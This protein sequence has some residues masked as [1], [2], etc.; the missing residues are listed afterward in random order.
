MLMRLCSEKG[1]G[2]TTASDIF[3]V[4]ILTCTSEVYLVF[5]FNIPSKVLSVL[6]L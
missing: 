5:F 1:K 6:K 3:L 2:D 4:K